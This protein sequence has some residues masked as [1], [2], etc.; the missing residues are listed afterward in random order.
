MTKVV[1]L[2]R[3]HDGRVVQE[4]G[5]VFDVDLDDP[6]F[7]G[8][9]WFVPVE[10]APAPKRVDPNARPAGAGPKPGSGK[11]SNVSGVDD[12]A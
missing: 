4:V 11:K 5:D 6:R 3:G 9:T 1:A 8:V 10:E 2:E 12:I 7:K